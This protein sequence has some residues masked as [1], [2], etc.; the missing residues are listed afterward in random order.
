MTRQSPCGPRWLDDK[1]AAGGRVIIDGAMGTELQARGV[2]MH[3]TAWS[4]AAVLSHPHIV[5]AIHTDYVAAGA[6]V[7]ITNTFSSG[8]HVLEPAGLADEVAAINRSAVTLARRARDRAA[9]GAVAIAGSMCE[10]VDPNGEWSDS[11]RFAASCREQADLLAEAG[12]DLIALEMCSDPQR[13]ALAAEA[14]L[15]TGLPVWLGVSCRR[16]GECGRLVSFDPPHGDFAAFVAGLADCGI[17][18]INVMHS[19]IADTPAGIAAVRRNWAGPMGAYPESGYFTMPDWHFVDI[20]APDDLV[21]EAQ[22]WVVSGVQ[23]LGGCC[24]LGV[25]HIRALKAAF[26]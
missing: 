11:A 22:G 20:I 7:I 5:E 2:P 24:G 10:W 23:I 18:V 16:D 25:D 9:G 4:G 3:E 1:L 14:A 6:E 26:S 17:G 15:A 19:T 12:V 13:S 21:R 8:R